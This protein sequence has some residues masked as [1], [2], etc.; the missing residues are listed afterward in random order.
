MKRWLIKFLGGYTKED[1]EIFKN[2]F[3]KIQEDEINVGDKIY[4]YYVSRIDYQ[5]SEYHEGLVEA[6]KTTETSAGRK[7]SCIVKCTD[8]DRFIRDLELDIKEVAL[9]KRKLRDKIVNSD[10][11][12][13]LTYMEYDNMEKKIRRNEVKNAQ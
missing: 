1:Y 13:F 8:S 7:L 3:D 6:I 4:F 5:T 12:T 11:W 10:K 2:S 9:S